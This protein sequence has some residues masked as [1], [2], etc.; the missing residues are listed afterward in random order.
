M[1]KKKAKK[2][3]KEKVVRKKR[4]KRRKKRVTKVGE[5]PDWNLEREKFLLENPVG[6]KINEPKTTKVRRLF[7]KTFGTKFSSRKIW[8]KFKRLSEKRSKKIKVGSVVPPSPVA[9]KK[10]YKKKDFSD[11]E[12][13][14]VEFHYVLVNGKVVSQHLFEPDSVSLV[15]VVGEILKPSKRK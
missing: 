8:M 12:M 13:I 11:D 1:A 2:E 10:E 6:E 4:R 5:A 3:V 14:P 7:N 9:L 15:K